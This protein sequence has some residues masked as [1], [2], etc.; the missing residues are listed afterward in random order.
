M[1]AGTLDTSV[2]GPGVGG[3]SSGVFVSISIGYWCAE[4]NVNDSERDW[5]RLCC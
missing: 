1:G 4:R 3:A 5:S 2:S